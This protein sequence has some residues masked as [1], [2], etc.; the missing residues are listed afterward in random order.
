MKTSRSSRSAARGANLP[1]W[2]QIT[3]EQIVNNEVATSLSL[4]NVPVVFLDLPDR[5]WA[6][7]RPQEVGEL[8]EIL[9]RAD[10][11]LP[12]SVGV[13]YC[14]IERFPRLVVTGTDRDS[15]SVKSYLTDRLPEQTDTPL[16]PEQRTTVFPAFN[17]ILDETFRKGD[18]CIALYDMGKLQ[19]APN[20]RTLV[21]P[22]MTNPPFTAVWTY[23]T[24][25]LE[26]LITVMLPKI[27]AQEA[28]KVMQAE[29]LQAG[30]FY[31]LGKQ[32]A[33]LSAQLVG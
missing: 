17:P 4:S 23:K 15:T 24:S 10:V 21:P 26:A 32:G 19:L 33:A 6:D 9:R 22:D 30:V 7:S 13:R 31:K 2:E 25:P 12:Q 3:W 18:L 27:R 11:A 5:G 14:H 1:T 29:V 16:P 28:S 8:V 20:W